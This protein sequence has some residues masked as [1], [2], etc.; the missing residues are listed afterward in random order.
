VENETGGVIVVKLFEDPDPGDPFEDDPVGVLPVNRDDPLA[1]ND[2]SIDVPGRARAIAMVRYDEDDDPSP[3]TFDGTFAVVSTTKAS[4]F[5]I[6]ADDRNAAPQYPHTLRSAVDY[7][8]EDSDEI[9]HLED[10]PALEADGTQLSGSSADSYAGFVEPDGGAPG[11]DEEGVEFDPE[12]DWGVRLR[13]NPRLSTNEEWTLTWEG[14][15]G[16]SGAGVVDQETVDGGTAVLVDEGKSFCPA[17]LRARD[18]GGTYAGFEGL[19]GYAGDVLRITSEPTPWDGAD[20]S[21]YEGEDLSYQVIQVV[22]EHS[23]RISEMAGGGAALPSLDCFGEVFTYEVRAHEHWVLKGGSSGY[24]KHSVTDLQGQ[25]TPLDPDE[26]ERARWRRHRVFEGVEF[27]N[28]YLSFLLEGSGA[29]GKE[30]VEDLAFTFST[31]G[32]YEPLYAVVGNDITDIEIS[33]GLDLVLV[34]R[35]GEGM[36]VFDLAGGFSIVGSPVN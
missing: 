29:A 27:E 32:G 14:K 12:G 25:C 19:E 3:L 17:G 36:V 31:E 33:P 22:D 16:I 24:L 6:D 13:C 10:E 4:V 8:S 2:Y 15:V 7:Y 11:C 34:D 20:C 35:A 26:P 1:S 18:Q 21:S 9:P 23:I 30:D 5:V 28:Y